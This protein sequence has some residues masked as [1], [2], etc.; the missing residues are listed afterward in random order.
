MTGPA[1]PIPRGRHDPSGSYFVPLGDGRFDATEH[2]G[3]AWFEDEQHI[4]PMLGLLT[5]LVEVDRDQRR[6]DGLLLGRLSFEILGRVKI[7]EVTTQVRVLR[8]GRG[9]ELVQAV[10]AQDGRDVLSLRAWLMQPG[11]TGS[12]AATLLERIPSPHETPAW[13][14]TQEWP[15]GFIRTV[16]VRRTQLEPGRGHFWARTRTPLVAG[17]PYS[18]LA[19]FVGL[20]DIANG[21]MT[22]AHPRKVFYPNVDLTLHL[23]SQP[24]GEWMGMD[25]SVTFG[26]GGTG[27]TS[28]VVH[29]E[30]GPVGVMAQML[31]VR[32]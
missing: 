7:A 15:G 12:V 6:D 29:D 2:V 14:P 30:N 13:D 11:D 5:H 17:T 4:A 32:L 25:T 16:E 20:L 1:E 31:T 8:P 21:M 27:V 22:R 24:E 10:A 3:G 18:R 19:G 28:S 23:F 26:A 9:V